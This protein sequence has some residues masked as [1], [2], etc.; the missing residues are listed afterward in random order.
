MDNGI[1]IDY[2]D[3]IEHDI[4]SFNKSL[5]S[6]SG[7]YRLGNLSA[8]R[9]L[10]EY[11]KIDLG[12]SFWEGIRKAG[13][14]AERS[15]DI[16]TPTRE[17]LR[18][19]LNHADNEGKAFFLMQMS[20]GSRIEEIRTLT[21]DNLH[22]E[23][24][25]PSFRI[26][27]EISKTNRPITKFFSEEAKY[28]LNEYIN[29]NREKKLETRINRARSDTVKEEYEN[30]VFPMGKTNPELMWNNLLKKENLYKLDKDTK[31]P[32]MGTHSLRRFFEDNIGHGKL[33]KYMLNKL[34]RSQEPYSF[35]T[36][37]KLEDVYNK[38]VDNLLIFDTPEKTKDE[39]N[40]LRDKMKDK[41]K[42]IERLQDSIGL[43]DKGRKSFEEKF[44]DYDFRFKE[45]EHNLNINLNP[46][47]P[48][49]Q[50]VISLFKSYIPGFFKLKYGR[51]P[52]EEELKKQELLYDKLAPETLN[53]LK[54]MSP[55]KI[56]EIVNTKD[57]SE[58]SKRV[59]QNNQNT[60]KEEYKP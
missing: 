10:L 44:K 39:V 40:R 36:K 38:Y 14:K 53:K 22:L 41:D 18:S 32:V 47:T 37:H 8:I 1:K 58:I 5:Q 49:T 34:T 9:K 17:Q 55:D 56:L 11:N 28:Y 50:N 31:H 24:N 60:K 29:K 57:L 19:I 52:T 4:E 45:I 20:S 43:I 2:L 30:M 7:S 27:K 16:I 35:K 48:E 23:T 46:E 26:P 42:Q 3:S 12:N 15:T 51:E 6:K 54:D 59:N 25:P 13:D 33:S 21:F